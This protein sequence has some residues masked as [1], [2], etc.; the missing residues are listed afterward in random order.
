MFDLCE[1]RDY[2]DWW[3]SEFN[4]SASA[5]DPCWNEQIES[6]LY[7][8]GIF[9]GCAFGAAYCYIWA[10]GILASGGN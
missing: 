10:V 4:C 5:T 8:G 1:A 2:K 7:R 6:D 9:L 3:T